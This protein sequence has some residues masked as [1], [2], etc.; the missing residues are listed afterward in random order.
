MIGD[1]VPQAADLERQPRAPEGRGAPDELRRRPRAPQLPGGHDERF[2]E[3]VAG[4]ERV[5]GL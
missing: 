2:L 4:R 1:I 3:T 5:K